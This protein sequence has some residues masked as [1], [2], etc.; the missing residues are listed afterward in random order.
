MPHPLPLPP[1]PFCSHEHIVHDRTVDP[2]VFHKL[3]QNSGLIA[4]FDLT[5]RFSRQEN[6]QNRTARHSRKPERRLQAGF[7]L[8]TR[9]PLHIQVH[10][11]SIVFQNQRR[12][13][14][15]QARRDIRH[16]PRLQLAATGNLHVGQRP[17]RD[18]P[19]PRLLLGLAAWARP[20][21]R[22]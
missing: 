19:V 8:G 10:F 15:G 21:D 1:T 17:D 16:G 7:G 20:D 5:P 18:C 11:N 4:V 9:S 14:D 22:G 3:I 12:R 6:P 13:S 2:E